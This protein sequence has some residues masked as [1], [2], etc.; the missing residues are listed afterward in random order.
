MDES[1]GH[2]AVSHEVVSYEVA[3]R[4]AVI[5]IERP[6]R[7]N[8]MSVA[9]FDALR[10][11]AE[12]ASDDPGVGAVVVRGRGG[13]FSSGIDVSVFGE[14][15][16]EGI[17]PDFIARLQASFTAFEECDKPTL[18]AIE[19]YCFGAGIQL[20]AACHLRAVAPDAELAVL[21]RRWGL[22]PDLGGTYRLPRLIGLGRATEL[23][24]TARRVPAPEALRI[25]LAE[26]ALPEEDPQA[27]ALEY[28]ARLAAGPGAVRRV[29]RL[30]R[31]NLAR[32]R[33]A[34]LAAE[35]EAQQAC[36]QGPDFSE[37]VTA[38]ME[39]REPEFVGS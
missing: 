35:A 22:V 36:I 16:E 26:V 12:E 37:A 1:A 7:R 15:Q 13:T 30:M 11:R 28:A 9:V 17:D 38:R 14:Q 6:D 24:M 2:E 23:A 33:A 21:E 3:D 19:G 8:A 32:D 31:E 27:Y 29:P 18:A 39:G 10:E 4:V 20:A 25:G 5:T 34:A